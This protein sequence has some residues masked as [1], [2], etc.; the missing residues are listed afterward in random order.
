MLG[1]A[2][3]YEC[4][5]QYRKTASEYL[6]QI[7]EGFDDEQAQLLVEAAKLYE[8][9]TRTV[10]KG[11]KELYE[12]APYPWF[13]VEGQS[14]SAEMRREQRQRLID[15]LALEKQA[16]AKIQQVVHLSEQV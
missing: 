10:L 6:H 8:R 1:N 11:D 13:L 15:A 5:A 2:W 14:W 12:I 7:S 9:I 16:I 4:V 3:I